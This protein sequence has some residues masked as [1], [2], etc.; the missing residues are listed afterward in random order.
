MSDA[1]RTRMRLRMAE[2]QGG[3][4]DNLP[5]GEI[6]FALMFSF[7]GMMNLSLNSLI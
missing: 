6:F 7:D 2:W 4:F 5:G 1:E 3:V